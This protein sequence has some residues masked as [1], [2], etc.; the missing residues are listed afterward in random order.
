MTRSLVLGFVG[1]GVMGEG[2]CRNLASKV[3]LPVIAC[4]RQDAPLKRLAEHGVARA[5]SLRELAAQCDIVFLSLP[6]VAEVETV[7]FA[8]DGLLSGSQL[9]L[10][11]LV[12]MSTS[13]VARTRSIADRLA[14]RGVAFADAP[15]ARTREAAQKGTLLITVGADAPLFE[16]L[17][18]LLDCMGTDVV[19]C[20]PVGCGQV[21]KIMNNMVLMITVNALAEAVAIGRSA[22]MDATRLLET[23]SLGSADS[24]ALRA[25]GLKSLATGEYPEQA[26]PTDYAAKDVRLALTLAEQG[27][28]D[29]DS[30]AATLALL[31]RTSAA[32]YGKLY[33]PAM[34]K[35]IE[36]PT[37]AT[38]PEPSQ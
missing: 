12:D 23:L 33:Y 38:R 8:A 21:V 29:A 18:P 13:D 2:M 16:R 26:F 34:L 17:K 6:S 15:V 5:A 31:E 22:G 19:H 7:C 3:G 27:Q 20:G 24:F 28:V 37:T 9:R 10:G 11:T 1:V 32:G 30:A 14:A 4:D 35:M 36:Q 25:A